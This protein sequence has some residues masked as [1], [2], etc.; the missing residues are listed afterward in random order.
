MELLIHPDNPSWM[1]GS[2]CALSLALNVPFKC[3]MSSKNLAFCL[4]L[5]STGIK[6]HFISLGPNGSGHFFR[7]SPT[8]I[9]SFLLCSRVTPIHLNGARSLPGDLEWIF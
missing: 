1:E 7:V 2:S 8:E 9:K 3:L 4:L 6:G 5:K